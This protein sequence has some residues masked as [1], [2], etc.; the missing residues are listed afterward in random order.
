[1]LRTI[2][3]KTD[4]FKQVITLQG[5]ETVPRFSVGLIKKKNEDLVLNPTKAYSVF[6]PASKT[7]SDIP[8]KYLKEIRD[9]WNKCIFVK[10]ESALTPALINQ[11]IDRDI[12]Y[13]LKGSYKKSIDKSTIINN[14][15][16]PLFNWTPLGLSVES[17]SEEFRKTN[18]IMKIEIGPSKFLRPMPYIFDTDDITVIVYTVNR[19]EARRAVPLWVIHTIQD[20]QATSLFDG[21][22]VGRLL[23]PSAPIF[24]NAKDFF[25]GI[26]LAFINGSNICVE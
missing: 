14:I 22:D 19:E 10:L 3:S 15:L 6:F 20:K 24:Y 12:V 8:G 25:K 17:P 7:V 13:V 5:V 26:R 23:A 1:M 18:I 16:Q 4:D 21:V 2:L 9:F 11:I